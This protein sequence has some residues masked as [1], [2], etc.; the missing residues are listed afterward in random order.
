MV[1]VRSVG[2]AALLLRSAEADCPMAVAAATPITTPSGR[3]NRLIVVKYRARHFGEQYP[4]LPAR[5]SCPA[6]KVRRREI[7]RCLSR[8]KHPK[9]RVF[10]S[11]TMLNPVPLG[12]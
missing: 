12:A 5:P 7:P 4:V 6:M 10:F 3:S 2:K 9:A 8:D 11:A 1:M